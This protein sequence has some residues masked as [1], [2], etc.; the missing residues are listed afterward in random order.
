MLDHEHLGQ[1]CC[2]EGTLILIGL[3]ITR[4]TCRPPRRTVHSER[5]MRHRYPSSGWIVQP[6]IMGA[7]SRVS[8]AAGNVLR[9]PPS[10]RYEGSNASVAETIHRLEAG[11]S[12]R[13]PIGRL[14]EMFDAFGVSLVRIGERAERQ[15]NDRP[16]WPAAGAPASKGKFLEAPLDA[17]PL[18]GQ[19][20]SYLGP[21]ARMFKMPPSA[22]V[23]AVVD[24]SKLRTEIRD[25][26]IDF[27]EV[28]SHARRSHGYRSELR[29]PK[30]AFG[31]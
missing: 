1:T 29:R 7:D 12:I 23:E 28:N 30:T 9:T 4:S 24:G 18:K 26:G 13:R 27:F 6:L 17:M 25:F 15:Q 10:A 2:V 20:P 16:Q 22:F 19:P 5:T 3:F 8:P 14:A 11:P 21:R 31:S